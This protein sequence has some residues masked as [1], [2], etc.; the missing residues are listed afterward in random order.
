MIAILTASSAA[1]MDLT[2]ETATS[3]GYLINRGHSKTMVDIVEKKKLQINGETTDEQHRPFKKFHA[4]L[5]PSLDGNTFMNYDI[6]MSS[7]YDD[8]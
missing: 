7:G 6:D 1:A 3:Y 2:P 8:L 5:D 4:Y